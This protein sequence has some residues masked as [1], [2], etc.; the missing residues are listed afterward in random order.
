VSA[1]AP[2]RGR[3]LLPAALGLGVF[4]ADQ[5][6]KR[7]VVAALGPEP[8]AR[9]R[10][11]VGDWFN[12]IYG[13]NTGIAFGMFEGI[14]V[15]FT[16]TSIL[17]TAGAVYAYVYHLP[18]RVPW[19]QV[20]IGLVVGGSLGNIADRLRLGYVVDFIQVG[21]WPLFNVAD[22]SISAGVSMLAGYLIFVGDEPAPARRT[23]PRDD[24]LL[25]DLLSRDLE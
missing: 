24:G 25:S 1:P 8:G 23:P 15:L 3:W 17:I 2:A 11:I 12:L 5:L 14:P 10:P 6:T 21:W 16:V 18:N 22:S 4:A 13:R 7:W 9:V 19:V 20:A